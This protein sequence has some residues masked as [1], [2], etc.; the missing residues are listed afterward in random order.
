MKRP[1]RFTRHPLRE[2]DTVLSAYTVHVQ[3]ND[4]VVSEGTRGKYSQVLEVD[5]IE[6]QYDW[7]DGGKP[8]RIPSLTLRPLFQGSD[9]RGLFANT[10]KTYRTATGWQAIVRPISQAVVD[11]INRILPYNLQIDLSGKLSE[12]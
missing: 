6:R 1:Q 2:Y 5:S 11:E 9:A 12:K 7:V 4:L 8:F 10:T 3:P